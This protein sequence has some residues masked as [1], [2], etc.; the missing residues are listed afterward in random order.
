VSLDVGFGRVYVTVV[1][2]VMGMMAMVV[3]VIGKGERKDFP[4]SVCGVD[5]RRKADLNE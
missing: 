1:L 3:L 2:V 5:W 4:M